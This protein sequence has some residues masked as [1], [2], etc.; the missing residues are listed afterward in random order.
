[1]PEEQAKGAKDFLLSLSEGGMIEIMVGDKWVDYR[2]T[3][4]GE[5]ES[6]PYACIQKVGGGGPRASFIPNNLLE[7]ELFE[8]LGDRVRYKDGKTW[9]EHAAANGI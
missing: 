1:M 5:K 6:G 4:T 2:V 7:Y 3:S 8:G 9:R